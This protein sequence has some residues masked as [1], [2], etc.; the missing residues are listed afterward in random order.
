MF[1]RNSTLKFLYPCVK[2]QNTCSQFQLHLT[3]EK[4]ITKHKC[5]K[6][7]K[8]SKNLWQPLLVWN[9]NPCFCR[10]DMI[11]L[12][13]HVKNTQ[14]VMTAENIN[15]ILMSENQ[16]L[17]KIKK[18]CYQS[19]YH[20]VTIDIYL[21]WTVMTR[22]IYCSVLGSKFTTG[23]SNFQFTL[24]HIRFLGTIRFK[25]LKQTCYSYV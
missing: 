9:I 12:S 22:W 16:M 23:S 5:S 4:S 14:N 10:H 21:S 2:W 17:I 24:K 15:S 18:K 7:K 3:G 1:N 6:L 25:K 8:F 11:L 19:C 13:C 20:H